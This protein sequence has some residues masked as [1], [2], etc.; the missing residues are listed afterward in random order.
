MAGKKMGHL[1]WSSETNRRES[2]VE[3]SGAMSFDLVLE[4]HLHPP[5]PL[6]DPSEMGHFVVMRERWM[7]C[8][9]TP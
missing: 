4:V 7:Q 2:S 6:F 1:L 9:Y 8:G 5:I 3:Q